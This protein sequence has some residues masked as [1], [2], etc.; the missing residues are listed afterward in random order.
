MAGGVRVGLME[1]AKDRPGVRRAALVRIICSV[2]AIM[3]VAI[4]FCP[5]NWAECN[6][7]LLPIG[8]LSTLEDD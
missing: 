6:G 5:R 3:L 1:G 8:D 7:Q 2:G 4:P